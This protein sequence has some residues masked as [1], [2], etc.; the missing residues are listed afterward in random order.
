MGLVDEQTDPPLLL[1]AQ[2]VEH[3][4]EIEPVVDVADDDIGPARHFLAQIVRADLVGER[5]L[6]QG[7][8]I[9][10]AAFDRR[11]ARG[12]QA[13]VETRRQRAGFAVTRLVGMLATLVAGRERQH[14]QRDGLDVTQPAIARPGIVRFEVIRFRSLAVPLPDA[15]GAQRVESQALAGVARRQKEDLVQR[16]ARHRLE[17]RKQCAQRLADAGRRLQHQPA[18]GMNRLVDG[19]RQ[20]TLTL[21]KPGIRKPQRLQCTI[22]P[23]P[24]G[25][26]LLCPGQKR[27]TVSVELGAQ[28]LGRAALAQGRF[29]LT[30]DIEID[31]RHRQLIQPAFGAQQVAVDL[32][33]RPVQR[34]LVGRLPG[35]IATMRLYLFQPIGVGVVAI[36]TAAYLEVA[37]GATQG[38]LPFVAL[39]P[40][41]SDELMT[42]DTFL[43]R[44]RRREA[45]IEIAALGREFAQRA[46]GDPIAQESAPAVVPA[47]PAS[48][49]SPSQAAQVT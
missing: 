37:I 8:A 4:V 1:L 49:V 34:P 30:D 46:D 5:G 33:L 35:K 38:D 47:S 31:E 10:P 9:E 44:R 27:L 12:G 32:G 18:P 20:R 29:A 21:A 15:Q 42:G 26:F 23:S 40:P 41:L 22:A 45:Q 28:C 6:P 25:Q 16:L 13:I 36:G 39:A 2:R 19:L 14:A 43:C 3:G 17:H 24:M 48:T 7:G 11:L